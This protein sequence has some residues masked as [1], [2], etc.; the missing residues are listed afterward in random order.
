M[1]VGISSTIR[2]YSECRQITYCLTESGV[3][4]SLPFLTRF[5]FFTYISWFGLKLFSLSVCL[6]F[7]FPS[8][9]SAHPRA[10][11]HKHPSRSSINFSDNNKSSLLRTMA[12]PQRLQT[13]P[14]RNRF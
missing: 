7:I 8:S 1:E 10:Q 11:T 6:S 12:C 3:M 4:P 14:P 9:H 5:S 13:S 2:L